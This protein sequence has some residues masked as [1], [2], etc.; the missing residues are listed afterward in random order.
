MKKTGKTLLTNFIKCGVFGWCLEIIFTALDSL[1]RRDY[2]LKGTTSLYMFPI[3]GAFSLLRPFFRL[4]EKKT[5]LARGLTYAGLI[6]TGEYLSGTLLRKKSL[7]PWD[8][9]RSKWHIK[10][11][12]R[13]DYLPFWVIA[14]LL[15]E[16]LL[17]GTPSPKRF[18]GKEEN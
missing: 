17:T 18:K 13:L 3:Y 11:I 5:P 4:L 2:R 10:G 7:C 15:F 1:R 16:K 8:Y 12:V 14:G 9:Q 6:F